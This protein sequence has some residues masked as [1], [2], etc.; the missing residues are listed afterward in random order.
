MSSSE[1]STMSSTEQMMAKSILSLRML[2]IIL[3]LAVSKHQTSVDT[4]KDSE[5]KALHN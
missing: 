4:F 3:E 5:R 1:K 2:K